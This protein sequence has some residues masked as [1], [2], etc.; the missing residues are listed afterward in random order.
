MRPSKLSSRTLPVVRPSYRGARSARRDRPALSRIALSAVGIHG[1][2]PRDADG[3]WRAPPPIRADPS[4][5]RMERLARTDRAAHVVALELLGRGDRGRARKHPRLARQ[6]RDRSIW[7]SAS[8]R[9]IR[10]VRAHQRARP[11]AR[12]ALVRAVRRGDR[13]LLAHAADRPHLYLGAGRYRA[14]APLALHALL[15]PRHDPLGDAARLGRDAARRSLARPEALA[16]GSRLH[17]RRDHRRGGR[18]LRLAPRAP[19]MDALFA[20]DRQL[21]SAIVTAVAN[22]LLLA[23]LAI[24]IAYLNWNGFIWWIAGLFV[25]R[26]RGWGRRGLW[27]AF[28]VYLG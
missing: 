15:R 1:C 13:V 20:F 16:Q 25:A 10:E 24:A 23:G 8:R 21:Y 28:T 19:L 17:R 27:A 3:E 2:R 6:L 7:R 18:L 22:N 12:G 4:V 26:A 11:R 14:D 5:R 9:E